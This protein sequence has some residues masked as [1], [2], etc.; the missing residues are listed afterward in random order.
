M[1]NHESNNT[2]AATNMTSEFHRGYKPL[3]G[4]L[5]GAGCG[6][7]SICFY[8]NGVFVGAISSDMG[9]S[10]GATQVGVSIMILMAIITAPIVGWMI[11]RYSARR[12]ALIS[13]PLFAASMACLSLVTADMWT[14]YAGWALMSIVGAGT[15]PITWTKL[16]NEWFDTS[17]GLA[18]GLTLAGTG[19]AATAAPIYVAWLIDIG[20]WRYAYVMLSIT[21]LCISLP[22]VYVFFREPKVDQPQNKTATLKQ[23]YSGVSLKEGLVSYH[24]WVL[25]IGI[26]LVAISIS[27]VIT[28]L[29]PLLTD[30]GLSVSEAASYAGLIGLS[31]IG[32][33]VIAGFLMDH[34]WAPLIAAIF[35]GMPCLAAILLTADTLTPFTIS[36]SALIIGLAAGAEL[37]LMAFLVSR[38][39]GLKNYG[40]LYGGIYIFFSLGAGLA[41][42]LFGLAFDS[43]GNY[44]MTLNLVAVSSLVGAALMLTLGRY[45][46]FN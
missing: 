13:L 9:W 2:I 33:R 36:L 26:L 4:A 41:P 31:V 38:Y 27:G 25:A 43:F 7:A 12:V 14:F 40:G 3:I 1:A 23:S 16:V 45:P 37:D 30:R 42:A 34:L 24:F 6:L 29:V 18:L 17:R 46:K 35:L 15:L 32:G 5:I 39:F 28:N 11:D 19:I 20:G 44:Q 22:A 8:T 10:R 21:L